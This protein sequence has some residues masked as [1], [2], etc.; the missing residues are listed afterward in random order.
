MQKVI[1]FIALSAYSASTIGGCGEEEKICFRFENGK[2]ADQANCK[3]VE[4]ANIAGGLEEWTW[5]NGKTLNIT[6]NESE[7]LVN[8]KP[9]Y[10]FEQGPRTC[11]G[12]GEES[13]KKEYFCHAEINQDSRQGKSEPN[14]DT[15]LT[16]LGAGVYNGL[17]ED[18]CG[19][20]G[21]VKGKLKAI[22]S[23]GK[24]Q[25]IIEEN[26][27]TRL[28]KDVLEDTKIRYNALG[29]QDF[30]ANIKKSYYDLAKE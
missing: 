4:C 8:G 13:S 10:F 26:E 14:Y 24:C 27:I 2:I 16:L 30:C 9:G 11:F 3:V 5:E 23:E 17:L 21:G 12:I 6:M 19:F 7:T 22:Y 29:N 20:D 15:C 28:V 1:F 18:L 25:E